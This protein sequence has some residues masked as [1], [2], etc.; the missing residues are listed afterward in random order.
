MSV[1]E[2]YN[3]KMDRTLSAIA[4]MH[5]RAWACTYVSSGHWAAH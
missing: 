3:S 2:V 5:C 4:C 1:N